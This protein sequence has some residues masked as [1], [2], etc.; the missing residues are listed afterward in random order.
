MFWR[1]TMRFFTLAKLFVMVVKL[2]VLLVV[3]FCFLVKLCMLVVELWLNMVGLF[4]VGLFVWCD[5]AR[6]FSCHWETS[7][8]VISSSYNRK[9]KF[10][11]FLLETL[12]RQGKRVIFAWGFCK[13]KKGEVPT[14]FLFTRGFSKSGKMEISPVRLWIFG[15]NTEVL[16]VKLLGSR[17]NESWPWCFGKQAGWLGPYCFAKQVEW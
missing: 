8:I 16:L 11:S 7:L 6:R 15:K 4:V 2:C 10:Y 12:V 5:V 13:P 17:G 9:T 1:S 14:L 3:L